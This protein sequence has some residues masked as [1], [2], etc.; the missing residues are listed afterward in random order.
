LEEAWGQNKKWP[1]G[2]AK[3][4]QALATKITLGQI[5]GGWREG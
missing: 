4:L 3:H 2:D 1:T 5:S